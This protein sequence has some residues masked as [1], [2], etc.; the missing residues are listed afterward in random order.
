M[1]EELKHL[2]DD[3]PGGL[4]SAPRIP[5][6]FLA[7]LPGRPGILQELYLSQMAGTPWQ[8]PGGFLEDSW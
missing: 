1:I 2:L 7:V 3:F 8:I 5:G 4:Y 6:G